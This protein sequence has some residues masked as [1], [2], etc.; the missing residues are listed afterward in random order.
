MRL[1][2][3]IRTMEGA[4]TPVEVRILGVLIEKQISTPD[5][6]PLTFNA[7][8]NACN[9][10]S[11]RNPVMDLGEEEVD[12]ALQS[13][14]QK[15][16]VWQVKTQGSRM[17]KFE[18]NM[19]DVAD[20]SPWELA[21]LCELLLRGPQTTGELRTRSSRL[22]EFN[23]VAAV[24]HTLGKLAVHEKGPFVVQLSRQT[25]Q[26]ERRYAQL[27]CEIPQQTEPESYP[28]S[29]SI[30]PESPDDTRE[31][32]T[33]RVEI[34][35]KRVDALQEELNGLKALFLEFKKQFE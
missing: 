29:L 18:H 19:K 8:V 9:Q 2:Q 21:I 16:L 25:G 4:L 3:R 32:D 20:F 34:L 1:F 5:Y 35:E 7:L 22:A 13:L 11:N 14:R 30:Q 27:F 10:K 6:Y 12:E 28:E 26:K 24:E 33:E 15:H 31:K 17:P 23:G